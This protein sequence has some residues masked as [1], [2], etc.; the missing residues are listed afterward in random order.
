MRRYWVRG[1]LVIG[2][3]LCR[4]PPRRGTHPSRL[5]WNF[6]AGC[7]PIGRPGA[8]SDSLEAGL[9]KGDVITAVD[10]AP[11]ETM[12]AFGAYLDRTYRPGDRVTLTISRGSETIETMATLE[13]WPE[14][15]MA[16]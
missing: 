2:E 10:R 5:A 15:D 4:P 11:V 1:S 9:R 13:P 16:P 3:A 12:D 8:W 7:H 6:R 14:G